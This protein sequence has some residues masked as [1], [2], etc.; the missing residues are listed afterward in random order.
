[1][2]TI[3][4]PSEISQLQSILA[5][6]NI[7]AIIWLVLRFMTPFG[8]VFSVETFGG[9][10][11]ISTILLT[12]IFG[13]FFFLLTLPPIQEKKAVGMVLNG[14]QGNFNVLPSQLVQGFLSNGTDR[15]KTGLAHR[16]FQWRSFFQPSLAAYAKIPENQ[17]GVWISKVL[18]YGTGSK[19]LQVGDYL[20]RIGKWDLTREGQIVHSKWG[21][22][23][24]DALF[25]ELSKPERSNRFERC[26]G[27]SSRP[28]I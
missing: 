22:V 4:T 9:L 1:M 21:N 11:I 13:A 23:L 3:I 25:L 28:L 15:N 8:W 20:T 7:M 14:K 12:G 10:L 18:P 19:V 17:D 24:F 27:Y 16:G 6:A 2:K 5:T 26:L